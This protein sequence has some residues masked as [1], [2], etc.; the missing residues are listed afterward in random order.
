MLKDQVRTRS[1]M[2]ACLNNADQFKDKIVLDVGCGTGILSIFAVKAG[3]KHVYGVDN[4]EIADFATSIIKENGLQD[5]IT[6]IKGKMEEIKLP[7]EKVDII[8]SEWMGYFLLFESM[9]DTVLYARDKYLRE[10]GLM[11]PDRVTLNMVAIEDAEYKSD[12][13]GFWD[14]VY[15]VDMRCVKRSALSEPLVDVVLPRLFTSS[16]CTFFDLD[17]YKATPADLTFSNKYEMR[18]TESKTVHAVTCWF[19]AYFS[20]LDRPVL[21][22]TSPLTKTTHWQHTVFYLD[23]PIKATRGG[24]LKGSIAIRKSK[25]HFRD[26]DIKIS[27]HYKDQAAEQNSVKMFKLRQSSS[28]LS[29]IHI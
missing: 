18:I 20:R 5:K 12:K 26:L 13:F 10:G 2:N 7:V 22:S 6:I 23:E 17:L 8:I 28:Y 1:Y 16:T 15:G 24:I 9:L 11:L 19:D 25:L 29:L 3:A 4:A 14:N 27:F 21:L